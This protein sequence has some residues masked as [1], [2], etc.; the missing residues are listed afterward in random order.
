MERPQPDARDEGIGE[1]VLV[2][3]LC[4][5]GKAPGAMADNSAYVT[6]ASGSGGGQECTEGPAEAVGSAAWERRR[7][8]HSQDAAHVDGASSSADSPSPADVEVMR[9]ENQQLFQRLVIER[10]PKWFTSD[11]ELEL[12]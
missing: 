4:G 9:S 10:A 6:A 12:T 3:T 1:I 11:E 7:V 2:E 5:T 8:R